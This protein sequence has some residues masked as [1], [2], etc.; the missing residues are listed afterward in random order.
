MGAGVVKIAHSAV[1]VSAVVLPEERSSS[2][3]RAFDVLR[4]DASS[5]SKAAVICSECCFC[6][7]RE[8]AVV[9]GAVG[10]AASRASLMMA[11][12][13]AR[14]GSVRVLRRVAGVIGRLRRLR[15]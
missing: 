7:L 15:V 14:G 8:Q 13:G 2:L 11:A 1:S 4:V 12:I 3:S 6:G 9:E 5:S 10:A